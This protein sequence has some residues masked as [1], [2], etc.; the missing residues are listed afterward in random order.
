MSLASLVNTLATRI[1]TEFKAVRAPISVPITDAATIIV[2]APA[3]RSVLTV[4]IAGA[5][6]FANPTATPALN[7]QFMIRVRSDGTARALTWGTMYA[8]SGSVPLP[9]T[10][11][12]G[13]T[14]L[15]GFMYDSVTGKLH[16]IAADPL[17]Y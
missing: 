13:K 9:S 2:G 4:S 14:H 7:T 12:A 10:T 3:H 15:F 5:R 16:C 6:L 8:A 1:G 17:G 11:A